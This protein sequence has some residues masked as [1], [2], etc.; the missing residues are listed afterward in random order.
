MSSKYICYLCIREVSLIKS[1]LVP[2]FLSDFSL[3]SGS[4]SGG[5]SS[6]LKGRSFFQKENTHLGGVTFSAQI[7]KYFKRESLI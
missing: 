7:D 5:I 4:L 6:S 3:S 2:L 1:C